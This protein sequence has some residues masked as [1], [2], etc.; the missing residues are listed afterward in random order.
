MS[1]EDE[2]LRSNALRRYDILNTSPELNFD[3]ITGIASSVLNRPVCTLALV[4]GDRFWFK[5]KQGVDANEMP[6][7]K[8]FCEETIR[9]REV[10]VVPDAAV[11]ARFVDAPVV[12]DAPHIRFYAGAPL[13]TPSGVSIG[14]LCVLDTKPDT[15]FSDSNKRLLSDLAA[16]V[17]ELF[18]SRAQQ[19]ELLRCTH[20]I[21]H[22]ARHDPLTGLPNRRRLAEVFEG[23]RERNSNAVAL[24][25]LDL[26]GFKVVNDSHGHVA[27][28]IILQQAADRIAAC[29][30]P[31]AIA[32]RLGGDEFAILLPSASEARLED[33]AATLAHKLM[34]RI[35]RPYVS[36]SPGMPIGCSI[37]IAKSK[38]GSD[39]DDLL[40]RADEMLYRAKHNGRGRYALEAA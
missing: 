5:S 37:G 23:L 24:L 6:R 4:D 11:D 30:P 13:V 38:D 33:E 34:T 19:T 35:S 18:E 31:D 27:G 10:F 12:K 1:S 40:G 32:A 15:D 26:D 39:L 17:V 22:L 25:Y 36:L 28:D 16:T 8:A 20:E 9:G 2:A 21:A 7:S 29:L 14:S 3:R